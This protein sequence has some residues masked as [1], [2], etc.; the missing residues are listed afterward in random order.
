MGMRGWGGGGTRHLT[1]MLAVFSVLLLPAVGSD[2]TRVTND[3][4]SVPYEALV[5]NMEHFTETGIGHFSE[6]LFD[7]KRYQLIVGARDALFRLSMDGLKKL[8]RADWPAQV[9]C[10]PLIGQFCQLSHLIV[11]DV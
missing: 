2:Y 1:T 7:V 3:Y 5:T 4:T 6:I 11:T 8:E 9:K 10:R